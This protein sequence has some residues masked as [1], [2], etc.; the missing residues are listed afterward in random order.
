MCHKNVLSRMKASVINKLFPI[1]SGPG[2]FLS[3]TSRKLSGRPSSCGTAGASRMTRP[4]RGGSVCSPR[5]RWTGSSTPG[6][7]APQRPWV[8][9]E[10]RRGI[11]G[12]FLM[13]EREEKKS[14]ERV[15]GGEKILRRGKR[16]SFEREH[17]KS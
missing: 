2:R 4:S 7:A 16:E 15:R 5:R 9:I 12:N 13:A 17:K 8:H 10:S 1:V 6:C 3:S 14:L 11:I